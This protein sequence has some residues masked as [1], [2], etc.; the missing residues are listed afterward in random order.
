MVTPLVSKLSVDVSS[1]VQLC[2]DLIGLEK[3]YRPSTGRRDDSEIRL[4]M[5]SPS[6]IFILDRAGV[7]QDSTLMIP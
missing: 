7:H 1:S 2:K 3:I 4:A 6:L 5:I